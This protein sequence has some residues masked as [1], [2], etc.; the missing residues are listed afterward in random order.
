MSRKNINNQGSQNFYMLHKALFINE[1]YRNLTDS[2][3][4]TYAILNDRVSLSIKNN[5]V[6]DNGDIYFIFTNTNLEKLLSKSKNTIT[7]I[8]KELQE[9]D[10]LE[11]V[12]VGF[13]RP[14]KL[15]LHDI[16]TN[17]EVEKKIQNDD[18]D[19]KEHSNSKESQN[20]GVHNPSKGESI[21]PEKGTPESQ[22]VDPNYTDLSNTDL[23]NTDYNLNNMYTDNPSDTNYPSDSAGNNIDYENHQKEM[24]LNKYP[25]E[26]GLIVN[27]LSFNDCKLVMDILLKAKSNIEKNLSSEYKRYGCD[28]SL[29]EH[30]TGISETLNRVINKAKY[31]N[32]SIEKFSGYLMTS[33]KRYYEKYAD[34]M[35]AIQIER[36]MEN[37]TPFAK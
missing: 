28:F 8:K 29:E 16:E 11:Q 18:E 31:E 9:V 21:I 19:I 34:E 20:L 22:N 35:L 1:K 23:S 24:I 33:I 5:W 3:K 30:A 12:K 2:A 17:L 37:A 14:N 10:L 4:V 32:K 25:K 26:I 27:Q 6:D 7:K 36:D 13:N 15:Y